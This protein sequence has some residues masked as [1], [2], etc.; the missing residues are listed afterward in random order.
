MQIHNVFYPN[1][2]KLAAE[3]PLFDQINDPPPFVIVNDKKKM[4]S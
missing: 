4:G 1:L 3:D 2:L